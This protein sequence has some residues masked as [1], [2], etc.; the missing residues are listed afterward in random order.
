M[1]SIFYA[2][3]YF[4]ILGWLERGRTKKASMIYVTSVLLFYALCFFPPVSSRDE[5]IMRC[6]SALVKDF[7]SDSNST[8]HHMINT[9]E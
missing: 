4:F 5:Y 9:V 3:F 2:T 1:G 7:L 6:V 8:H